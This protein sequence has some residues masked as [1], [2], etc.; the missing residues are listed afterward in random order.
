[1]Q[2]DIEKL[3]CL[4]GV[5]DRLE[6]RRRIE[7]H[8]VQRQAVKGADTQTIDSTVRQQLPQATVHFRRGPPGKGHGQDL[9][10]WHTVLMHEMDDALR[11]RARLP[12]SRTSNDYY[13]PALGL[14]GLLLGGVEVTRRV[15]CPWL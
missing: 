1:M 10:A 8:E 14:N 6:R 12:N 13:R 5:Q 4:P 15:V 7:A 9:V 3:P 2:C 11:Q